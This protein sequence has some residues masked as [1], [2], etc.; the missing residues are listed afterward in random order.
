METRMNI[1]YATRCATAVSLAL[2]LST[3]YATDTSSSTTDTT[4]TGKQKATAVGATT[5]AVAGAVVGGPI[6]AIVGAGIGGVVG[7]EGTDA[8]GKVTT[9]PAKD[10]TVKNAQVALNNQGY[11]V[12]S[13]DGQYGPNTQSA[14]RR[15]QAERGLT[16]TGTL[17]DSTLT[18]LGVSR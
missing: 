18:A 6:G 1:K 10:G 11:N 16:Q 8:N 5:G 14:V 3:A 15:F 13:A 17:D 12:G 4:L 7:H 9:T 2:V